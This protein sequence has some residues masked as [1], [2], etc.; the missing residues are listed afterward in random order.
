MHGGAGN[1]AEK[2]R[3]LDGGTMSLSSPCYAPSGNWT[4]DYKTLLKLKK[5]PLDMK[6]AY[7]KMVIQKYFI[8]NNGKVYISFSGGKDSTVLLNLVRSVFPEIP[9]VYFDTG[10]EFPENRKFVKSF[11]NVVF[12]KPPMNFKEILDKFGYPC[13]GKN[14][15]HFISLAQRGKPSGIKQMEF[16]TKYGYKKFNYLVNAPFKISEK[17][18]NVMKKYPAH[19]YYRDTGRCP[20]VGTRVDESQIREHAFII[21][22]D[23]HISQGIPISA[24]LS[25]WTDSDI[26]NY[27][28]LNKIALS[29]C[30]TRLGY[31]RTG[32]MFCM[33]GIMH[34]KN[35]FLKLKATHPKIWAQCM[36]PIN[37][38]GLDL[39]TVLE[40][41]KIPTGCEQKNLKDYVGD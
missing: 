27:I 15:A 32:C 13:I 40:F 11:D 26:D 24:P 2:N 35:R 39:K 30:Y 31:E 6:I 7:S 22:G 4:E 25:I 12:I 16:E 3:L 38:G 37:E 34:D 17:C 9:A 1:K 8:E 20:I 23:N 10:M 28:A 18:C 33:F 21:G 14:A 19:Q 36:K 29:D 5:M 41:M